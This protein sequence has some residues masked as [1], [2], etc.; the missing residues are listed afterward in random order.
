MN[1]K[2][3]RVCRI[4]IVMALAILVG[5]SVV[6]EWPLYVPFLGVLAALL[7]MRLCRNATKE[8]M[9][10]ERVRHVDAKASAIAFRV[11]SWLGALA[12]LVLISL[13]SYVP[14]ELFVAGETLAYSIC[15]LMLLH[16]GFYTYYNRKL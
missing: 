1:A 9:V 5:A 13:R 12:A 10:D 6:A 14:A 11:F 7:L 16:L 4:A 15:A 3:F 8:V 2:T